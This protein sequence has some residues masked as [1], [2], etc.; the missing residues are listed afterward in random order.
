MCEVLGCQPCNGK[1]N[2]RTYQIKHWK[3]YFNFEKQGHKFIIT[4]VYDTPLP[5]QDSRSC[6]KGTYVKYIES[7]LL[8]FLSDQRN[9][10]HIDIVKRDLYSILGITNIR[11]FALRN[12]EGRNDFID[13]MKDESDIPIDKI[14]VFNFKMR[15]EAKISQI[16]ST[17]LKSMSKRNL[18]EYKSNDMISYKGDDGY[19]KD[20]V[21]ASEVQADILSDIRDEVLQ[22][23]EYSSFIN[24]I[25]DDKISEFNSRVL[26]SVQHQKQFRDVE[27]IF[28]QLSITATGQGTRLQSDI[29][30]LP[31]VV[32]RQQLNQLVIDA[33]NTQAIKYYNRYMEGGT[34]PVVAKNT[35]VYKNDYVV[36]QKELCKYLLDI[37][38][39]DEY[40]NIW[41]GY[42][43]SDNQ[44]DGNVNK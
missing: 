13:E 3:R 22:E 44:L 42:D 20:V 34:I 16:L 15:A 2:D 38:E 11:F 23:M 40:N 18:I 29:V 26:S 9:N 7:L 36:T 1:G 6:R 28:T 31:Y 21:K 41:E 10:N 25:W 5:C 24:V 37:G 8:R 35:T 12:K 33:L 30:N 27:N 43:L 39:D 32:Q 19:I 4:E 17:A 14:S